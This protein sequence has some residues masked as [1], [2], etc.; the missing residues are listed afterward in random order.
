MPTYFSN[1]FTLLLELPF[2]FIN[3]PTNPTTY[4]YTY[5]PTYEPTFLSTYVFYITKYLIN[6]LLIFPTPQ[7]PNL[8]YQFI[9][10]HPSSWMMNIGS[11]M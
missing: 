5:L 8:T 3:L 10:V 9:K 2:Q 4:L 11:H 6:Y 1:L 7:P